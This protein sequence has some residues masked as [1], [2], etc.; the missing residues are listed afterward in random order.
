MPLYSPETA[1]GKSVFSSWLPS[2]SASFQPSFCLGFLTAFDAVDHTSFGDFHDI[3][4]ASP[5][6]SPAASQSVPPF[7]CVP[8]ASVLGHFLS[9]LCMAIP[10]AIADMLRTPKHVYSQSRLTPEHLAHLSSLPPA[11]HQLW[12]SRC[13]HAGLILVSQPVRSLAPTAGKS[14]L[15]LQATLLGIIVAPL[16]P[17]ASTPVAHF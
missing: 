6:T 12:M 3:S 16:F 5:P 11:G 8:H 1:L 17:V 14:Y 9:L 15:V 13:D 10:M 7:S 2:S 4:A